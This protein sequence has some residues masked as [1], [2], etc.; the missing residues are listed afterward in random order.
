[1]HIK[2]QRILG[3]VSTDTNTSQNSAPIERPLATGNSNTESSF[4]I[5]GSSSSVCQS[6]S[7]TN[8]PPPPIS[9]PSSV[10]QLSNTHKLLETN[11]D[12]YSSGYSSAATND[13]TVSPCDKDGLRM[14]HSS[15][16]SMNPASRPSIHLQTPTIPSISSTVTSV[17]SSNP[18]AK[19]LTSS[20]AHIPKSKQH[21]PELSFS[22]ASSPLVI[23]TSKDSPIIPY[24]D[25]ELLKRDV[26][27]R[28]MA[29][30][31]SGPP[32]SS[33]PTSRSI[34]SVA[35][36][37]AAAGLPS[38][39]AAAA[40]HPNVSAAMM[41]PQM[42]VQQ[43]VNMQQLMQQYQLLEQ[44]RQIQAMQSINPLHLQLM[45]QHQLAAQA[46]AQQQQQQ[47]ASLSSLYDA[48]RQVR[49]GMPSSAQQQ[50]MMFNSLGGEKPPLLNDLQREQ[51]L[52][53][54]QKEK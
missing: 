40:Q 27:V 1:M 8:L 44:Y 7:S 54:E 5:S 22:N 29:H 19:Y 16:L 36:A 46:A 14:P 26:E 11:V 15:H 42:A 21:P 48:Q 50:W 51:E 39:A 31:P 2:K 28:K 20:S 43:Q 12:G 38:L 47:M 32:P 37:T 9:T 4:V 24:R 17:V 52:R 6:T 13:S 23:D 3:A 33:A 34:P 30:T 10:Y 41:N 18:A 49:P 45:Q 25:P 53:A 35:A